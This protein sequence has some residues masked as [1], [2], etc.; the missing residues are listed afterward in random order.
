MSF[1][2]RIKNTISGAAARQTDSHEEPV[3]ASRYCIVDV[4]VGVH[5]KKIHDIGAVR[6]D[7]AV[8]HS[9]DKRELMT[10][11]KDAE[12]VCGHNIIKHDAR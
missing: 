1:W 10:F 4:E 9:A 8:Y 11:I 12:F 6:W 2:N 3:H 5:D 7:G